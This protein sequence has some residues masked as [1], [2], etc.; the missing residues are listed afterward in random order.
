LCDNSGKEGTGK[1][2][3]VT[4][5]SARVRMRPSRL[6]QWDGLFGN[7]ERKRA[8]RELL[9]SEPRRIDSKTIQGTVNLFGTD[10]P[11][12]NISARIE[13]GFIKIEFKL[14]DGLDPEAPW[15]S[16]DGLFN[17]LEGRAK[18]G[19]SPPSF[20]SLRIPLSYRSMV[21]LKRCKLR[22][23]LRCMALFFGKMQR[24]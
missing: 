14:P 11:K 22:C 17:G 8:A 21:A 23:I 2:N 20:G 24:G 18:Q 12:E 3:A 13:Q 4:T 16:S 15:R 6:Y 9:D 7:A 5:M 10:I 1:I 19:C